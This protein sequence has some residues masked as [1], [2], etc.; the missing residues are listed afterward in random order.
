MNF[1]N[2]FINPL[3][4]SSLHKVAVAILCVLF[5]A[6]S[7]VS[8][9]VRGETDSEEVPYKP[10]P[11]D[12]GN[13][14]KEG[15]SL[16]GE[17]YLFRDSIPFQQMLTII[18][19][20]VYS[21]K[22]SP[23]GSWSCFIFDTKKNMICLYTTGHMNVSICRVCNFPDFGVEW[24]IPENGYI[25]VNYS[26]TLYESCEHKPFQDCFG[27]KTYGDNFYFGFDFILTSLKRK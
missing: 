27:F 22:N 13:F 19:D 3:T 24:I 25:V 1:K 16:H 21:N 15:T 26:G 10:C 5:L 12:E 6:G 11:C 4:V 14:S 17:A 8:C 20:N 7:F 23:F 18:H 9:S 2:N